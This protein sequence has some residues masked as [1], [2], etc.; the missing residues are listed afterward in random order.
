MNSEDAAWGRARERISMK[1]K[2]RLGRLVAALAYAASLAATAS[3]I[4]PS[5]ASAQA[6]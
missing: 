6:F 4:A 2:L 1:T 3:A 5:A